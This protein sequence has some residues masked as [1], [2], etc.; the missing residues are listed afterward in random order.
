ASASPSVGTRTEVI[1]GNCVKKDFETMLQLAYLC[2]TSPRRDDDAFTSQMERTRNDLKNQELNPQTAFADS[3]VS[4]VYNN[5]VRAK[6]LKEAD[7]DRINYDRLL[8]IY[9]ERFANAGDFEFYLV[10]DVNADS[11]APLLAKYLGALPAKGKKEKYKVIDQ[12]M[13]KG[14]R[15]CFF[16]KEQDTP[17][18]L[19]VFLYHAPMKETMR[20]NILVD[21]LQQ[22]M[23][24]LYTESVREDEGG[25]Y[26]V[27]VGGYIIDYPEEIAQMQIILPTAPE[28]RLAMTS[29]VS[30]G[31]KK[32]MEQGPSE[33]NLGKIKEYMLRS[34]QEDLKNNGY[35]MNS[36]ISKT[37]Y[38][39]ECVEGYEDCVQGVT[40][41]DIKQ[42]AQQIFGSGNRLVVGMETPKE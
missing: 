6:R 32:M 34:H 21:M 33:E 26:S 36:L 27:P 4:V 19:N 28:K 17:N 15:E 18:S 30:D 31:I 29:V 1:E 37:R 2:F 12:R 7:L 35:W 8:E 10:G 39:Q 13:T 3:I 22:A 25:A 5:N 11:V 14:E 38:A 24:M 23:T 41:E 42:V 16:T 9:R 40:V 20:N